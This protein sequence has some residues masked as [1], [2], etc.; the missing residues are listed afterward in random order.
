MT[1]VVRRSERRK[2]DV[3]EIRR[4]Y[5]DEGWTHRQIA[6]HFGV[7]TWTV[8]SRLKRLGISPPPPTIDAETVRKL[9]VDDKWPPTRIAEHLNVS[10]SGVRYRL[11]SQG[12]LKVKTRPPEPDLELIRVLYV[13]EGWSLMRLAHRLGVSTW[14]VEDRLKKAGVQL[15]RSPR[16]YDIRLSDGPE[17]DALIEEIKDL[18]LNKRLS[19][20]ETGHA[21]YLGK[22]MVKRILKS[23][24][25]QVP[26]KT[27]YDIKEIVHLYADLGWTAEKIGER[28][29]CKTKAIFRML[30]ASGVTRRGLRPPLDTEKIKKLYLDESYTVKKIAEDFQVCVKTIKKILAAEGIEKRGPDRRP[31]FSRHY[32]P[33]IAQLDIGECFQ[34]QCLDAQP[35]QAYYSKL[36]R[37]LDIRI[38][39]KMVGP[40]ALR[41]TR[42][43]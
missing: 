7:S 21:V 36:A 39:T 31:R 25:I 13:D 42:Y 43:A 5:V 28:F 10:A 15:R 18:Y 38:S 40:T 4:L 2:L 17:R 20:E 33:R 9:Y 19:V 16:P 32:D 27:E 29:G 26:F 41:I 3:G 34:V 1:E 8:R 11:E 35:V 30:F 14:L 12:L 22:T 24:G 6:R 37:Q 23:V